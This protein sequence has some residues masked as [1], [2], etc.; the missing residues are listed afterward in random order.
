M[1]EFMGVIRQV[2]LEYHHRI[3]AICFYEWRDNL[4]HAKIWNVE[5]SPFHIALGL[6][7]RYGI[8]KFTIHL[9]ITGDQE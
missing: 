6:C 2:N 8:S 9:L 3:K 1:H 4:H 5:Q 7:D